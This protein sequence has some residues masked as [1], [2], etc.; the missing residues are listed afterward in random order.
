MVRLK[1]KTKK[2]IERIKQFGE[3]WEVY[4]KEDPIGQGRWLVTTARSWR[5]VN[6]IDDPDFIVEERP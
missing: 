5:W 6:P 4:T 2:G 1:G 3:F